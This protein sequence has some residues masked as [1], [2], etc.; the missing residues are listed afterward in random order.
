V[1]PD[2]GA[3]KAAQTI[4]QGDA[5]LRV[6]QPQIV[7]AAWGDP[8]L[9]N[10]LK[11]PFTLLPASTGISNVRNRYERPLTIML[12]IVALVLFIACA[13][14]ANLLLA[15]AAAR[16]K[17]WSV[18]LALG[19]SRYRLVRLVLAESIV[20]AVIGAAAGVLFA[21]W[22]A[23]YLLRQISPEASPVFLDLTIDWRVFAFTLIVAMAA[24]LLSGTASA[25]R[26]AGAAPMES[27]KGAPRGASSG[28]VPFL[29]TILAGQVAFSLVLLVV[30]GLFV[31]TFAALTA[32]PLGFDSRPVLNVTINAP[33]TA[34]A[35][36]DRLATFE[37]VRE[38]VLQVPGVSAAG[39]ARQQLLSGGWTS[40]QLN[41]ISGRLSPTTEIVGIHEISPGLLSALGMSIVAGRDIQTHD[42]TSAGPVAL[43]NQAFVR[44]FMGRIDPLG[45]TVSI[46]SMAAKQIVGIVGDVVYRALRDPVPPT[47]YV[48][49][50][51]SLVSAYRPPAQTVNLSVRAAS[52]AP[53]GLSHSVAAA[54][55][56]VNPGLAL[57]FRPLSGIVD[58][59]M[60]Q[61]RVVAMLSAFFG[62]LALALA[63]L[64]LYGVTAYAVGR[65]RTELGIRL[66]L[67]AAPAGIVR[68]VLWRV[69]VLVGAGVVAG[70]VAS[71]WASRFVAT[72]LYGLEPHD[73]ATFVG[74]AAVLA[75]VAALAGWIPA[76]RASRIDP[77]VVLRN[78]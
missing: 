13:N 15:R 74:A 27:L 8:P 28:G 16:R 55:A 38:R 50:P 36:D 1:A 42:T 19:A 31:R 60:N 35:T 22:G 66:A 47:V 43:V 6:A 71:F 69:L 63:A 26:A 44:T 17:D 10:N 20:L 59:S 5:A 53:A 49:L 48:P 33:R 78:E 73:P 75:A 76:W 24:T 18:R 12:G 62:V 2:H 41:A 65:R 68:L 46:N 72:L 52:D 40:M 77:A 4:E 32:L 37:R 45:Q 21:R 3:L 57:T 61:E 30:A 64:G 29:N 70:A 54:V 34:V 14:I 67:G 7:Q 11:A 51:Q 9:N 25:F 23:Y 58:A 39:F 56:E